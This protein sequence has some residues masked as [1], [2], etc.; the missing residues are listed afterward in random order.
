MKTISVK[1]VDVDFL[2]TCHVDC[3]QIGQI[4]SNLHLVRPPPT[5][6]PLGRCLWQWCSK[7][8]QMPFCV[9]RSS[10]KSARMALKVY[11]W[12]PPVRHPCRQGSL[13]PLWERGCRTGRAL[14]PQ[15]ALRGPLLGAGLLEQLDRGSWGGCDHRGHNIFW[16]VGLCG[17]W[18]Q[19]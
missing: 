6:W 10:A 8:A 5:H 19:N 3:R 4:F 2:E 13:R 7:L 14:W 9:S 12:E 18:S 15:G 11:A 16:W 1:I 17:C